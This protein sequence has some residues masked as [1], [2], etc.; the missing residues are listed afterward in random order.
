MHSPIWITFSRMNFLCFPNF[1]GCDIYLFQMK[2]TF[3][4][5]WN[6]SFCISDCFIIIL[7]GVRLSSLGNA[8]TNDLLYQPQMIDSGNSGAIGGIKVCRGNTSTWRKRAQVPF[9]PPRIPHD[10]PRAPTRGATV[11]SQRITAWTMARPSFSDYVPLNYRVI[12]Q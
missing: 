3:W 2:Y 9:C 5:S 1:I 10:Q 11:G 4:G 12:T 7:S 6:Y 8:S